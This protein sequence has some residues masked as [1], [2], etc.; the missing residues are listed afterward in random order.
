M[1]RF[2]FAADEDDE[3]DDDDDDLHAGR[4][5]EWNFVSLPGEEGALV[6]RH[7]NNNNQYKNDTSSFLQ[8]NGVNQGVDAT[9]ERTVFVVYHHPPSAQQQQQDPHE[10]FA[11]RG[12]H[13]L[14]H[15]QDEYQYY[16]YYDSNTKPKYIWP[17]WLKITYTAF[18]C[19]LIWFA[20]HNGPPAPPPPLAWHNNNNNNANSVDATTTPTWDEY[21]VQHTNALFT[22]GTALFVSLPYHIVSW[23]SIHVHADLSTWYEEWNK[24]RPCKLEWNHHQ[25]GGGGSSSSKDQSTEADLEARLNKC[26]VAQAQPLARQKLIQ[27]LLAWRWQDAQNARQ[28]Y[29]PLTLLASSMTPGLVAESWA[30]CLVQ[31]VLYPTCGSS[32][33]LQ[34]QPPLA[35]LPMRSHMDALALRNKLITV[36]NPWQGQGGVV[37]LSNVDR[38]DETTLTWL[39]ETLTTGSRNEHD[40]MDDADQQWIQSLTPRVIFLLTSDEIGRP[41]LIRHMREGSISGGGGSTSSLMLDLRHEWQDLGMQSSAAIL[42]MFALAQESVQLYAQLRLEEII[43]NRSVQYLFESHVETLVPKSAT[44]NLLFVHF[45]A[46]QALTG[47]EIVEYVAWSAD[48]DG[49]EVYI[50]TFSS[51]GVQPAEEKLQWLVGRLGV[52]VDVESQK[53]N[54]LLLLN[55]DDMTL[56]MV[57]K[58]CSAASA[59]SCVDV[60][61]FPIL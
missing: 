24:P 49:Q 41:S 23:W 33:T 31:Q 35:T 39:L 14:Y 45:A 36:L 43:Q 30:S 38:L 7:N 37:V 22:A 20:Y 46:V 21:L 51:A 5:H 16:Y 48:I 12:N 47:S 61:S 17:L 55:Y 59:S 8:D 19:Q 60:C 27:A 40:P 56:R 18:V 52:C 54:E 32:S 42:P 57:L 9:P 3:K 50:M 15:P 6:E 44:A 11:A 10:L 4:R 53:A 13:A 2:Q 1:G 28:L 25:A 58:R 29:P 26:F 34:Q